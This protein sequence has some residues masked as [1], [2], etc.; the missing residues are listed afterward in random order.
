MSLQLGRNRPLQEYQYQPLISNFQIATSNAKIQKTICIS[1][2]ATIAEVKSTTAKQATTIA[3]QQKE[4]QAL[5][6]ALKAQAVQI[7]TVNEQLNTQAT[8]MV[9]NN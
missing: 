2:F 7:Q 6:E 9:V 5:T 1:P 8:R 3:Q 4:I